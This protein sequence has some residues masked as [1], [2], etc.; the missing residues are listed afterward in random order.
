MW[1]RLAMSFSA[2]SFREHF[3]AD[4]GI[5][6]HV[7]IMD[8]YGRQPDDKLKDIVIGAGPGKHEA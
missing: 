8:L 1:L 7:A 5:K 6:G 3:G 4:A 2:E